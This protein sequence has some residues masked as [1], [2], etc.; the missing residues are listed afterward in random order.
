[1]DSDARRFDLL[2]VILKDYGKSLSEA[3]SIEDLNGLTTKQFLQN[4][5]PEFTDTERSAIYDRRMG[6]YLGNLSTYCSL[7]P[8]VFELIT[9]L[10]S[11]GKRIIAVTTNTQNTT[12][13]I[14][15][16]YGLS[17]FF[18]GYYCRE[19][20]EV[21][22]SSLKNYSLVT[23][24]EGLNPSKVLVLEDSRVGITSALNAGLDCLQIGI[25]KKTPPFG[26]VLKVV[27]SYDEL[28]Q[29]F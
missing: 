15:K 6:L 14:L 29:L 12:R 19:E 25:V 8:G 16:Y 17:E 20:I 1:M 21:A 10:H 23:E 26:D 22:G 4:H 11:R 9:G 3:A 24:I 27:H 28:L 7:L 13:E 5:F 18:T 2:E